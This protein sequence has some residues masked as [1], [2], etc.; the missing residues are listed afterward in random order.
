VR[1]SLNSSWLVG[2]NSHQ[3]IRLNCLQNSSFSTTTTSTS[4]YVEVSASDGDDDFDPSSW[5]TLDTLESIIGHV[6]PTTSPRRRLRKRRP[7]NAITR[8]ADVLARKAYNYTI[9]PHLPKLASCQRLGLPRLVRALGRWKQCPSSDD[10]W[11][12]VEVTDVISE[13]FI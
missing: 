13:L 6:Q 10:S 1:L 4:N 9:S 3:V 11:V 7:D 8:P 2:D 12:C 5:S